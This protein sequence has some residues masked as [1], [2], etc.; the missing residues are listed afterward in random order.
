MVINSATFLTSSTRN[1]QLPASNKI[2]IALIGRSNVGKSSLINMLCGKK[3]L[4]KTSGTPGKTRL[5]NHFLIDNSWY[6]VDLPGY[7]WA[8]ASKTDKAQ[9][10]KMVRDYLA[11]RENLAVTIV[12]IDIRHSPMA[13]DQEFL[14]W[15]GKSQLPFAICFT[16]SDKL[17]KGKLSQALD[18]YK[19]H[20]LKSWEWLPPIFVTSSSSGQ[21]KEELLDYFETVIKEVSSQQES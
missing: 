13:I 10:E 19:K 15:L 20:L 21:G 1:D 16:K 7:G 8:R 5:I 9:W 18:K 11:N 17:T 12:L 14:E 6:L 3:N 4:A 2:E